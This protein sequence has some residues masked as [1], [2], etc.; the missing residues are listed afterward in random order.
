M[1]AQGVNRKSEDQHPTSRVIPAAKPH[2]LLVLIK[3]LGLALTTGTI[4]VSLT[5]P[6][7]FP[8]IGVFGR[9]SIR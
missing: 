6:G 8:L 7:C 1:A 9:H 4:S 2:G 5:Y 3:A